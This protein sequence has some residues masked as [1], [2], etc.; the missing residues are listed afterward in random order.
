[1]TRGFPLGVKGLKVRAT[2][3]DL[4]VTSSF[5]DCFCLLDCRFN[6]YKNTRTLCA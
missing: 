3:Y 6:F 5:H 1:M 4:K 2:L